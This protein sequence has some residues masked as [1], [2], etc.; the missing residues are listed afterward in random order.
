MYPASLT[1]CLMNEYAFRC[2]LVCGPNGFLFCAPF[3]DS[4][5]S[6]SL[7]FGLDSGINEYAFRCG[8][9]CGPNGFLFCALFHG[10][11]P[12][13]SLLF[14]LDSVINEY[15]FRCG[16]VCGLNGFF[17]IAVSKFIGFCLPGQFVIC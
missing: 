16:L 9:I 10:S 15:A 3:H 5:P 7:L 17:R 12:S 8:L 13:D 1:S 6:D 2:G 4:D 11:D 14:G